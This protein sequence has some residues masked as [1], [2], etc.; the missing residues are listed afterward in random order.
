MPCTKTL[1]SHEGNWSES[2]KNLRRATELT[3]VTLTM[4]LSILIDLLVQ[5][6]KRE[7]EPEMKPEN[8]R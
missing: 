2:S 8:E 1:P 4:R 7:I 3:P 5:K 6:V